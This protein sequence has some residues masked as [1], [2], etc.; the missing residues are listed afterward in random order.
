MNREIGEFEGR[1][2]GKSTRQV[3]IE[4][5]AHQCDRPLQRA[6]F[7]RV[8]GVIDALPVKRAKLDKVVIE[9]VGIVVK[10]E[11]PADPRQEN[12]RGND[13]Q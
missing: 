7:Q 4:R 5:E 10:D 12:Q 13:Q 11:W 1:R 6:R 2:V 3:V 8:G 9:D